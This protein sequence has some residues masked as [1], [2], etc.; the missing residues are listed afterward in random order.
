MT[1]FCVCAEWF[2]WDG[3]RLRA[4]FQEPSVGRELYT[5]EGDTG[6]DF[7]AFENENLVGEAQHAAEVAEL[8]RMLL[9]HFD[10]PF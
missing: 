8:R 9:A 4:R 3:A 6:D 10:T 7:G 5:H 1:A 2:H